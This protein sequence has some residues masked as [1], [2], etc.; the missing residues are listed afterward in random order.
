MFKQLDRM[1]KIIDA[2]SEE[3]CKLFTESRFSYIM[4]KANQYLKMGPE[5]YRRKD[6]F[7]MPDLEWDNEDLE[8]IAEGCRQVIQ[9][10][11]FT[12]DRPFTGLDITGFSMLFSLFHFEKTKVETSIPGEG[13]FLD[14]I[15]MRHV[16]D[17]GEVIYYNLVEDNFSKPDDSE[18][19]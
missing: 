14:K 9:G 19:N 13:Q 15:K 6:F 3:E 17:G 10:K 5:K 4:S 8:V 12:P 11:G 7:G 16:M 1:N 18:K 2:L